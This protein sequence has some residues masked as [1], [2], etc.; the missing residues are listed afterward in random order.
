MISRSLT[1]GAVKLT[2][3][4]DKKIDCFG[5]P[6]KRHVIAKLLKEFMKTPNAI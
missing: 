1:T 3:K 2:R 5:N 4:E 6:K